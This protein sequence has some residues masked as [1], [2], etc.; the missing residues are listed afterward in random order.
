MYNRDTLKNILTFLDNHIPT[1]I[2]M[3]GICSRTR[4]IIREEMNDFWFQFINEI[5]LGLYPYNI[6]HKEKYQYHYDLL[7]EIIST[8]PKKMKIVD[9]IPKKLNTQYYPSNETESLYD[10]ML[11]ILE[12]ISSNVKH[13]YLD[14]QYELTL[15]GEI[16]RDLD[17][18][19]RIGLHKIAIL[20]CSL[21]K[22]KHHKNLDLFQDVI[23]TA[24]T[25]KG[26]SFKWLTLCIL[27]YSNKLIHIM[28]Y[29][30]E[31][32][33]IDIDEDSFIILQN[34]SFHFDI[35]TT[36]EDCKLGTFI[37][38]HNKID[39]NYDYLTNYKPHLRTDFHRSPPYT[40]DYKVRSK[41]FF[42]LDDA[43]KWKRI[44]IDNIL[45]YQNVITT[46]EN[47]TNNIY[48]LLN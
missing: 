2:S 9:R 30:C 5:S 1:F 15:N 26:I 40:K 46:I 44:I 27:I 11:S 31:K 38:E 22:F 24:T 14:A 23:V 28:K 3:A 8:F 43:M 35:R 48:V 34:K 39:I 29:I 20:Y 10:Y 25:Y 33:N 18:K 45:T 37:V 21:I 17:F 16:Y 6:F 19:K 41:T 13:K 32:N 7:I 4:Y 47:D 12:S 36:S 42:S